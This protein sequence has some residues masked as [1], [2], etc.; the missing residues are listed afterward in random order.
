MHIS[1]KR[2]GGF[3]GIQQETAIDTA[4]IQPEEQ[5]SLRALLDHAQFFDLPGRLPS[6]PGGADRFHYR[7]EVEDGIRRHTVEFGETSVTANLRPL[8]ERLEALARSSR[9][10]QAF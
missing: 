1:Y 7:I 8:L 6:A 10:G 5:A 9:T 3:A 4:D 2:S